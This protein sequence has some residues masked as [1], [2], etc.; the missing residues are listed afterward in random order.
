MKARSQGGAF[1]KPKSSHILSSVF[2]NFCLMLLKMPRIPKHFVISYGL[3][4]LKKMW[5]PKPP[6]RIEPFPQCKPWI[7]WG[8]W[9]S[10]V[11]LRRGA[12]VVTLWMQSATAAL[13]FP[14]GRQCFFCSKIWRDL[15]QPRG[16]SLGKDAGCRREIKSGP[17]RAGPGGD[18][19][20]AGRKEWT[21]LTPPPP[22]TLPSPLEPCRAGGR[23]WAGVRAR[24]ARGSPV[25][26]LLGRA[27]GRRARL[28]SVPCS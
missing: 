23:G 1:G 7:N 22:R 13:R 12:A 14:H 21:Q 8:C 16:V 5:T 2:Q 15:R 19:L 18:C 11:S 3:L 26:W 24:G 6:M 10:L 27:L 17:L 9:K 4:C 25:G 28:W 20:L